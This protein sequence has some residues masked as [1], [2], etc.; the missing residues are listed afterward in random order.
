[1][2]KRK[3]NKKNEKQEE[4]TDKFDTTSSLFRCGENEINNNDT[5]IDS[6]CFD[7]VA[8]SDTTAP[9]L[10][11]NAKCSNTDRKYDVQNRNTYDSFS[12]S[13]LH[14]NNEDALLA[15]LL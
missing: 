8:I 10:A 12:I 6:T 3:N 14:Q 2:I 1:M 9:C 5:C 7:S 13:F 11:V 4:K 15:P